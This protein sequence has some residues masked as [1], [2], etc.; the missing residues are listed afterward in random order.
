MSLAFC[1]S[2]RLDQLRGR[3]QR[4]DVSKLRLFWKWLFSAP[5]AQ[6]SGFAVIAWWELR[7]I[8]YNLIV[9]GAGFISLIIFFGS[10]ISS[11]V[12]RP[13]EDAVEPMAIFVAP[14]AINTC[15]CAGWVV[16]N[17]LRVVWPSKLHLFGPIL[18]KLGL[19]F[20]LFAVSLP[21]T[22][23]SSYRLLQLCGIIK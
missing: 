14:V 7:R 8:P 5:N 20:S 13:G 18:F 6:R 11:G 4:N 17:V 3:C 1:C 9:G 12:L 19:G 10:I 23:W 16:E 22:F 2:V 21:A 15:Y